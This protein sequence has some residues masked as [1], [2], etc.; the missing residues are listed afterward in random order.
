VPDSPD[1]PAYDRLGQI[2]TP[3]QSVLGNLEYPMVRTCVEQMAARISVSSL[4]AAPGADHLLPLRVPGL[5]TELIV[6]N[7]P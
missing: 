5:I 3:T 1:P 2:R 6:C 4:L 7:L